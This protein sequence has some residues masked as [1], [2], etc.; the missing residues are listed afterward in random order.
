MGSTW[1]GLEYCHEGRLLGISPETEDGMGSR[2]EACGTALGRDETRPI[3]ELRQSRARA[4]LQRSQ[5][6]W[7][8]PLARSL[9][10]D[11]GRGGFEILRPTRRVGK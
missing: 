5:E 8:R 6:S 7:F 1:V 9:K 2:L 3:F 4:V 10:S 11:T